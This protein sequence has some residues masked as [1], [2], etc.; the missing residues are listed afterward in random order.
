MVNIH[1]RFQQHGPELEHS[2]E[3]GKTDN[4]RNLVSVLA[5]EAM[6]IVDVLTISSEIFNSS[7]A[8]LSIG[9]TGVHVMLFA[10][11]IKAET[12]KVDISSR[13]K[14]WFARSRNVDW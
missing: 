7:Q 13:S 4:H 5:R 14:L 3:G 11:L 9:H 12:F 8:R 6:T 1:Q 2:Q 10:M